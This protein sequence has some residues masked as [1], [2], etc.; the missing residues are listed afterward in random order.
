MK[1]KTIFNHEFKVFA[2]NKTFLILTLVGP[3]LILGVTVLPSILTMNIS[4]TISISIFCMDK[5]IEE[6]LGKALQNMM[7][8]FDIEQ[9][10]NILIQ[11]EFIAKDTIIEKEEDIIKLLDLAVSKKVITGYLYI[12][13]D[14]YQSK[15]ATF[16][17]NKIADYKNLGII[18]VTLKQFLVSY[19][20]ISQGLNP[21]LV[22]SAFV[23]PELEVKQL[24]KAGKENQDFF[25]LLMTC[26]GFG[27]I[28]YMTTLL[29][30]QSIGRSVLTEKT[31]KTVE[32]LLSSARPIEFL[33]GKILGQAFAALLQYTVW[34]VMGIIF[35][36][37][38][39][40]ILN[41]NLPFTIK[42]E[43]FIYL[44]VYFILGFF[45]YS[46]GFAI[47]GSASDDEQNLGQLSWPLIIFL[48]IPI[49]MISPIVMNSDST[50]VKFMSLFPMTS[51]I[52]MFIR[53]VVSTPSFIEIIISI[54]L[55]L[56]TI[57]LFMIIASKV[58]PIG[59]L[60]SGR[61]FTFKDIRSWL[62]F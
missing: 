54:L 33:Y 16:V 53:V 29:Y 37:Y 62:K 21:E 49:V 61:K 20:L 10:K 14:F 2:L 8:I 3:F 7:Q 59:L 30:G 13:P 5:N 4:E 47:I 15:K 17:V 58:F 36:K 48:M 43:Y 46:A 32:V 9:V 22:S 38:L 23:Q 44:I 6:N 18:E 39:G 40:P 34:A 60:M 35:F 31:S 11:K 19:N 25:A 28:L 56:I 27:M 26:L 51:P 55:L 42:T 45:L 12:D 41:L 1:I 57:A 50:F 24:T 52:V